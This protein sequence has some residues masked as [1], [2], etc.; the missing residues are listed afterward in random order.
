MAVTTIELETHHSGSFTHLISKQAP[1]LSPLLNNAVLKAAVFVPYP[2]LYRFPYPQAPPARKKVKKQARN[3]LITSWGL[4]KIAKI[5]ESCDL[6]HTHCARGVTPT[7]ER[8]VG[9]HPAFF[10]MDQ[11]TSQREKKT[12]QEKSRKRHFACTKAATLLRGEERKEKKGLNS[13]KMCGSGE[14]E[15]PVGR[16]CNVL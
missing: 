11:I 14:V 13:L 5:E 16:A 12:H 9:I 8:G 6:L 4:T 10:A 2:W 15:G 1:Q 3:R 7:V